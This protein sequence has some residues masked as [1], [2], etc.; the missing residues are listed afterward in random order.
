MNAMTC[1][2]G[3][4]GTPDSSRHAQYWMVVRAA[5]VDSTDQQALEEKEFCY[6]SVS[7][8]PL[9][10]WAKDNGQALRVGISEANHNL[11]NRILT[12]MVGLAEDPQA[13]ASWS[14]TP[15]KCVFWRVKQ[16]I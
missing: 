10:Y 14:G 7:R 11:A 8:S 15:E 9:V 13:P 16:P 3:L 2:R 1:A 6:A 12:D 5:L 4:F